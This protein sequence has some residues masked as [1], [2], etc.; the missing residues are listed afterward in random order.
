MI[1][2]ACEKFGGNLLVLGWGILGG[3]GGVS[4]E[5]EVRR[6]WVNFAYSVAHMVALA[7][8]IGMLYLIHR[9]LLDLVGASNR[10]VVRSVRSLLMHAKY[11]TNVPNRTRSMPL[12]S[13]IPLKSAQSHRRKCLLPQLVPG[14]LGWL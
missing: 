7:L 10:M 3:G 11:S 9:Q 4:I 2:A 13:L 14:P 1:K 5:W 8:L 6:M 12:L